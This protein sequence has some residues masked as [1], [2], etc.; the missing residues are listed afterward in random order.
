LE[1]GGSAHN[2]FGL[3]T[4]NIDNTADMDTVFQQEEEKMCGQKMPVDIVAEGDVL[5]LA[6]ESMDFIVNSHV[7]EHFDNPVGAILEWVRVIKPGGVIFM[8][9]PHKERTFDA[10]RDRTTLQHLVDDYFGVHESHN[11]SSGHNHVWITEDVVELVM[12]MQQE[13]KL[14]VSTIAVQDKDDKVGNGF[15]VVLRKNEVDVQRVI[16]NEGQITNGRTLCTN[17]S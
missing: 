5:P 4:I 8:I 6:D 17:L 15:T 1:I 11:E 12:W 9:I 13:L 3:D 16:K 2:S 14:P 7:L 10:T